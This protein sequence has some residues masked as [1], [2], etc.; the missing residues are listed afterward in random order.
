MYI[1]TQYWRPRCLEWTNTSSSM[2]G[3]A[4]QVWSCVQMSS[5]RLLHLEGQQATTIIEEILHGCAA[6]KR[7]Q[8]YIGMIFALALGAV[9]IEPRL[10]LPN[11]GQP[12]YIGAPSSHPRLSRLARELAKKWT[13]GVHSAQAS[14]IIGPN[15]SPAFGQRQYFGRASVGFNPNIPLVHQM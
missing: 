14:Q 15:R 13:E 9:L 4:L 12:K 11:R 7:R 3:S 5:F 1:N 6:H 10:A 8:L 2:S